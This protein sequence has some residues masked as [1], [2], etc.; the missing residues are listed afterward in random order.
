MQDYPTFV[1]VALQDKN[2]AM[3]LVESIKLENESNFLTEGAEVF[4]QKLD[5]TKQFEQLATKWAKDDAK[6]AVAWAKCLVYFD[7]AIDRETTD[8][9]EGVYKLPEESSLGFRLSKL[10][11]MYQQDAETVSILLEIIRDLTGEYQ[12]GWQEAIGAKGGCATLTKML[13][14]Y[15]DNPKMLGDIMQTMRTMVCDE[16]GNEPKNRI[17]FRK[18]SACDEIVRVLQK[19]K[20]TSSEKLIAQAGIDAIGGI[21]ANSESNK[22]YFGDIGACELISD[23]AASGLYN[24]ANTV[25]NLASQNAKKLIDLGLIDKI[26]RSQDSDIQKEWTVKRLKEF[27]NREDEEVVEDE[28]VSE[29]GDD[30]DTDDDGARRARRW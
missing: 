18:H 21:S 29:G 2:E 26:R 16:D 15:S 27:E 9:L 7:Q 23:L 17:R 22:K 13:Q 12:T 4:V 3:Q 5:V 20:G 11:K 24:V 14:S 8:I 25:Y 28:D 6:F 10:V 30:D 1:V 19:Y